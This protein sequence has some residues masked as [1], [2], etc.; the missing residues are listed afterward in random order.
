MSARARLLGGFGLELGGRVLALDSARAES[1]LAHLLLRPGLQQRGRLAAL[2]WPESSEAQ[3]RTNLRHL[4]HTLRKR[5]PGLAG[6]LDIT[7]QAVGWR[8]DPADRVDVVEFEELLATTG[9]DRGPALAAAVALHRGDLLESHD[10]EWL[11]DERDRLRRRWLDALAELGALA[12]EAG[13]LDSAVGHAERLLRADPVR[14]PAYRL[15]MRC[16]AARGER[17]RA[18]RAYHACVS[19]LDRELGVAVST[20]TRA[21]YEALLPPEPGAPPPQPGRPPLVGRFTER[22][23]AVRAWRSAAAG[24]A[25]LVLVG[26]EPGAGKTR[27]AEEFR[28]WCAR[29]GAVGAEARC[30]PGEGAPAYVPVVDWLR[31]DALRAPLRGLPVARLAELARLLPEIR[32]ERP[33]VP[34]PEPLPEAEQQRRLFEAVADAVRAVARPLLLLVDD[35]H[36]GDRQTCRLVH[37]LLRT[38]ADARLLVLATARREE[39]PPD[40]PLVELVAAATAGDRLV[41][42]ELGPL[43][44]PETAAL[45]RRLSGADMSEPDLR[46]LH[47]ATGGNPL[48]VVEAVRAG[49]AAGPPPRL[50]ALIT[51]RLAGLRDP[52]AGLVGAAAVLGREFDADLLARVAGVEEDVLVRGLDELW[53][54]RIVRE[55]GEGYD[56]VH[57]YLREVADLRIAPA[58]R[59]QLHRRAAD[60]LQAAGAPAARV[61][62]HRDRGGPPG[63]AVEAHRRAAADAVLL[64][65]NA[66]AVRHLQRALELLGGLPPGPDR[67]TTELAVRTALLAPL[68]LVG[69]YSSAALAATHERHLELLAS[70]GAPPAPVLLRS[71][72]LRAMARSDFAEAARHAERLRAA[73]EPDDVEVSEAGYVLGVA[74]F[75]QAD[76]P[77]ARRW[78]ELAVARYRPEDRRAH[79]VRFGQD[80]KVLALARLACTLWFLGDPA[81]ARATRAAA[82]DWA[83]R[84]GHPPN[85]T[86]ALTF[87][88]LLALDLDE[89]AELRRHA[90]ALAATTAQAPP[91]MRLVADAL[92]GHVRV[93]D[94]EPTAGLAAIHRARAE[95]AGEQAAPGLRAILA[96]VLLAAQLA[97]GDP[98]AVRSTAEELRAMGGIG[99]VWGRVREPG[100]SPLPAHD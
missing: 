42:I 94:G 4:L 41:E 25:R 33:D 57:G 28:D 34:A 2:L 9:P 68:V 100:R 89:P 12:E 53:R 91:Q 61:A 29:R 77:A 20:A 86:G 24:R 15:L 76:F 21:A 35:L 8:P 13:D 18:L 7:A 67:D 78:F 83:G 19:A 5:A 51:A 46:R 71:L 81:A 87:A 10:D 92:A 3:A 58:R 93:L 56:F 37:Y 47:L 72:A 54:R 60:A 36:H 38:R 30:H 75:W 22:V 73:A 65:A 95:V 44:L 55:R 97:A 63:A 32:D 96:R 17:G 52:A 82:L 80:P 59:R 88:A 43:A 49:R 26:G 85:R 99:A 27:L 98:A 6:R 50:R 39:C 14:E 74:A 66:D 70:T 16:H 62:E 64:H 31:S 90:A 23:T 11:R 48:F 69:G 84:A 79:L 45:A 1:L 40:H